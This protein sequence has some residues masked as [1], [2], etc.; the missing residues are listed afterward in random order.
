MAVALSSHA[1]STDLNYHHIMTG[2]VLL[3]SIAEGKCTKLKDTIVH[4]VGR[5]YPHLRWCEQL[6]KHKSPQCAPAHLETS[7]L[8]E[9]GDISRKLRLGCCFQ[10]LWCA[11][12][13]KGQKPRRRRRR[14]RRRSFETQRNS[15]K[16]GEAII[17]HYSSC[18][19][20]VLHVH[21][22]NTFLHRLWDNTAPCRDK[23]CWR[24]TAERR[25]Q[26]HQA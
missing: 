25:N 2:W 5:T 10:F 9:I 3:S 22:N 24:N 18:T 7:C 4:Y 15:T 21:C 14:R 8:L 20:N 1:V 19:F 12:A 6:L 11:L 17:L 13:L 26:L 16:Q 23:G